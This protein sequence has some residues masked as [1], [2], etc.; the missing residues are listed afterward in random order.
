VHENLKELVDGLISDFLT[1]LGIRV[2]TFVHMLAK[3]I[4]ENLKFRWNFG[5]NA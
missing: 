4:I 5:I 3:Y 2:P 1:S